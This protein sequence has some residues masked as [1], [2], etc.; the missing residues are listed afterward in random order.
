MGRHDLLGWELEMWG[1]G[2]EEPHFPRGPSSLERPPGGC[3]MQ[4]LGGVP[5]KGRTL[6]LL[7]LSIG[8]DTTCHT[9]AGS[10]S[11]DNPYSRGGEGGSRPHGASCQ[12][13]SHGDADTGSAAL[14]RPL[15][16]QPTPPAGG[17]SLRT[18]TSVIRSASS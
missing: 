7:S 1:A 2:R 12:V 15:C 4:P 14:R 13:T 11:P 18:V 8:S 10:V 9:L 3:H 6:H 17:H 16:Q 5:M